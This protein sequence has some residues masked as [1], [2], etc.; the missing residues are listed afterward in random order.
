M[1]PVPFHTLGKDTIRTI[2]Q[3]AH[4]T[5]DIESIPTKVIEATQIVEI[6]DIKTIDRE[7]IQTKDQIIKHLTPTIIKIDHEI[8]HTIGTQTITKDK[9]TILNHRNRNNTRYPDSQNKYRRITPKYQRQI[10]QVQTT[11]ETNSNPLVLMK[12]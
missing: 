2:D 7:I 4:R 12:Q 9:E 5:I 8:T 3:E 11:E 1:I 10:N 6:N